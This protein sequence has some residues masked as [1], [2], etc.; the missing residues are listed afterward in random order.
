MTNYLWLSMKT[1]LMMMER[2]FIRT[3]RHDKA[4]SDDDDMTTATMMLMLMLM[5]VMPMRM[6][7]VGM[8]M[9]MVFYFS[10]QLR[11]YRA[12]PRPTILRPN[13]GRILKTV[14]TSDD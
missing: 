5:L 6:L 11:W 4:T 14:K 10:W 13:T 9:L 8:M 2:L 12:L 1:T 7:M 3:V